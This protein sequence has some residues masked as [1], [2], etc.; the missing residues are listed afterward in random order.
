MTRLSLALVL[1][2]TLVVGLTGC[3]QLR[4]AAK[5]SLDATQPLMVS[6]AG[7][8]EQCGDHACLIGMVSSPKEIGTGGV[9]KLEE[10]SRVVRIH[11]DGSWTVFEAGE[12]PE[13]EEPAEEEIPE[14]WQSAPEKTAEEWAAEVDEKVMG[15]ALTEL[16][17]GS[18]VDVE[19]KMVLEIAP[20]LLPAGE[21]MIYTNGW[22]GALIDEQRLG[23]PYVMGVTKVSR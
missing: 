1:G 11:G 18:L 8:V 15:N 17:K 12:A 14:D 22:F 10:G 5:T 20:D 3:D 6:F 21:F 23:S 7:D 13:S 9:K 16:A 19:G 2:S 4:T